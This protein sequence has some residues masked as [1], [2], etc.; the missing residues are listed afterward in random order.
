MKTVMQLLLTF[1]LNASWQGALIVACAA[2]GDW[3]L[4][5]AAPR[6]R[7]SLW[8][9]TLLACLIIPALSCLPV[10]R[11]TTAPG[12]SN[13]P[14]GPIPVVTSRIITPGIEDVSSRPAVTD[15]TALS[16]FSVSRTVLA[17]AWVRSEE[18]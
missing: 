9:L 13:S 7:H 5:G 8:V 16:R 2:A 4:R 14:L 6:F 11:T 12:I 18:R 10:A 1:V 17:P 15:L 3:M